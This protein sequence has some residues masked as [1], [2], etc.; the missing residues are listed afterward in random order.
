MLAIDCLSGACST[1][2]PNTLVRKLTDIHVGPIQPITEEAAREIVDEL[3]TAVQCN[4][5]DASAKIIAPAVAIAGAAAILA[6]CAALFAMRRRSSAL[7]GA[8]TK[9]EPYKRPKKKSE[10]VYFVDP[11]TGDFIELDQSTAEYK[12]LRGR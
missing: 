4:A 10:L 9:R 8:R 2:D 1:H 12:R 5:R 3:T 7:R 6:G 11:N